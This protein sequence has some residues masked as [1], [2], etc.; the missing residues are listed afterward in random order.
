[1]A[2]RLGG[3]WNEW[4]V[5]YGQKQQRGRVVETTRALPRAQSRNH[6]SRRDIVQHLSSVIDSYFMCR[7]NVHVSSITVQAFG[8]PSISTEEEM[9]PNPT[10]PGVS[11]TG[12]RPHERIQPFFSS[13][14]QENAHAEE[15]FDESSSITSVSS[16]SRIRCRKC[17]QE[18]ALLDDLYACLSCQARYH[19]SCH[20]PPIRGDNP[21]ENWQCSRCIK[22]AKDQPSKSKICEVAGCSTPVPYATFEEKH[23]CYKHELEEKSKLAQAQVNKPKQPPTLKPLNERKSKLHRPHYEKDMQSLKRKRGPH[24]K[25]VD[26]IKTSQPAAKRSLFTQS[27]GTDR[28]HTVGSQPDSQTYQRHEHAQ[29]PIIVPP[30]SEDSELLQSHQAVQ[31][32]ASR[33]R[34]GD[35]IA[36][37]T[38]LGHVSFDNQDQSTSPEYEPP[39]PIVPD[40]NAVTWQ[41]DTDANNSPGSQIAS[42]IRAMEESAK[43]V[44]TEIIES[45]LKKALSQSS[46]SMKPCTSLLPG[47]ATVGQLEAPEPSLHSV[48]LSPS[49]VDPQEDPISVHVANDNDNN[50]DPQTRNNVPGNATNEDENRKAG[51]AS[52]PESSEP[53]SPDP[54]SSVNV[55]K[56]IAPLYGEYGPHTIEYKR[57][58]RSMTY[59]P[60]E[61]DRYLAMQREAQAQAEL[62]E[63][64]N[65]LPQ[66]HENAKTQIWG[67]VDPR[68][69]WP[70]EEPEGWYEAKREEVDARGGRKANFGILLTPQV[71]KEREERGWHPNQNQDRPTEGTSKVQQFFELAYGAKDLDQYEPVMVDGK[72]YMRD[73]AGGEKKGR[74][75][76]LIQLYR[77]ENWTG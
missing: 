36:D 61:L 42:D 3:V 57:Q 30:R 12:L 35:T 14:K 45:S 22:K 66:V 34:L 15:T 41:L 20:S 54:V 70:K 29:S 56:K 9:N 25:N 71:R 2:T 62:E 46:L 19:R 8:I 44:E 73:G 21:G 69:V 18:S 67:R 53:R 26:S 68:V 60:T 11:P 72:L 74:K 50:V 32:V 40:E 37:G 58:L 63:E 75:K 7:I 13:R 38:S 39:P 23:K 16:S 4:S 31:L 55:V 27:A 43:R 17:K 77:A 48:S 49:S 24:S 51:K 64:E 6:A 1:M 47:R 65:F 33:T 52:R 5:L 76:K 59:D 28:R 10:Q